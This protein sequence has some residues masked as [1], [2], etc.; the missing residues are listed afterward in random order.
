VFAVWM[1]VT[2]TSLGKVQ[3]VAAEMVQVRENGKK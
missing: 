3:V 2:G 1:A